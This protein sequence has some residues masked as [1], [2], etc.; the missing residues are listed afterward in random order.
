MRRSDF[1][2]DLP[3]SLV[4]QHPSPQRNQSRLLILNGKN[5]DVDDRQFTDLPDL[6]NPGDLLIFNDTRVMKARLHGIKQSGGKVEVLVERI[7]NEHRALAM[8]R[9]SKA[10]QAGGRITL[11]PTHNHS[12]S[13]DVERSVSV[14]VLSRQDN[15][16][17]L[18]FHDPRPVANILDDIGE[19]PLPPY[20][21]HP[22]NAEDEER[23]QTVYA[24]NKGAVAAPTAGLHFDQALLDSLT[25]QGIESAFITLHVG[26]GTFEPMRA[27]NIE[28]HTMHS[29]HITVSKQ[30]CEQ[31]QNTHARG[32]RVIA[33]GT[34][35]ARALESSASRTGTIESYCGETD[36][37]IYPGYRFNCVD[38]LITNF[39]LPES[40]LLML[41][42][43]FAGKDNVLTAY[44]HAVEQRY[45]FF[46]Y[47][48]AMFIT[49]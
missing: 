9:A 13:L 44:Q 49:R 24:R 38:A 48:D 12:T 17:E 22:A 29:E 8:V 39:H 27:D 7:V 21:A 26:A 18:Y 2:F 25:D 15:L 32:G 36:I 35:S 4:A 42:C 20:I 5:G 30:V 34:T 41:V 11:F 10:P 6:L 14:E 31:V 37:F 1:Y 46:S 40:T 45:R 33:V 3:P 23:Y 16:F 47:G 19:V 43:A 28:D